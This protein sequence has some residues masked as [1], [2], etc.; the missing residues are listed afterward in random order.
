MEGDLKKITQFE[1]VPLEEGLRKFRLSEQLS[2]SD[3]V[4]VFPP[5]LVRPSERCYPTH[6]KKVQIRKRSR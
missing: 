3:D 4:V 1:V 2:P 5:L 6:R